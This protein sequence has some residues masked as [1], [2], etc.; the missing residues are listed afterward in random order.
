MRP[1]AIALALL[2]SLFSH[3]P[4]AYAAAA[5]AD[6]NRP[7]TLQQIIPGHYIY[8]NGARASGVIE[9]SDGV[10][11]IDALTTEAMARD[12]RQ[13]I[14]AT[15]GKPVRYLISSTFHDNYT[16]GN[17]AY[18]DALRIGH[19][20]Y[21]ED[22]LAMLKEDKVGAA[23]EAARLPQLSFR[24]SMTLHAGGKEIRILHLGRGHTRGDSV[25][26]VPQ[27]RI[28]YVSELLFYDRFPWMNSGYVEWIETIDKVLALPADI[29]VP[30]QGH[31]RMTMAD[32][33]QN[34]RRALTN[35]RQVLVDAR[36]A[37]QRE[38]AR[39]ASEDQAVANVQLVQH[40]DL[41]GYQQQRETVVRRTYR[42]LKGTLQ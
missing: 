26:L 2:L 38:I 5:E 19:E 36:D 40:K 33:R 27:D 11:V 20:L 8:I 17:L 24:E 18:Q 14:A 12:E 16:K 22:L 6:E 7:G 3:M 39:G 4:A 41:Q 28:A 10:V 42:A 32:L 25:V 13:K 29:F 34:S 21:N 35:M 1:T 30:G 23:E 15:I 31:E 37:V 9:T